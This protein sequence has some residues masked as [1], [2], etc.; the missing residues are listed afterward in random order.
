MA[1]K[2]E[3]TKFGDGISTTRVQDVQNRYG[4]VETGGAVGVVKTEGSKNEASITFS[5]KNV[6]EGKFDLLTEFKLPAGSVIKAAYLK[7]TEV[8]SAGANVTVGTDGTEAT[9][10]LVLADASL[11]VVGTYDVTSTLTG[12]WAAPLAAETVVGVAAVGGAEEI[13][14][15]KLVVE[16]VAVGAA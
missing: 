12:T 16:Y 10:G 8:F 9:N 4:A 15:A 1:N 13:G 6:K 5:G 11:D 14:K 7:V 2:L 3:T